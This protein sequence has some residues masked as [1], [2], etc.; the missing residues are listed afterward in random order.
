MTAACD[1]GGGDARACCSSAAFWPAAQRIRAAIDADLGTPF[2]GTR[3]CCCT[4]TRRTYLDRVE[5]NWRGAWATDGGG[6]LTT[7]GVHY[8]DL[9]QWSWASASR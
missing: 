2:L 8:V 7:Q 9:L 3:P 4:A 5:P 6:V 1:D